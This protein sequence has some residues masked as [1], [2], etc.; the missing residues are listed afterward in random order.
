MYSK[1]K[2]LREFLGNK[3]GAI[4][5]TFI[6]IL[7][8]FYGDDIS[9]LTFIAVV[10]RLRSSYLLHTPQESERY[11]RFPFALLYTNDGSESRYVASTLQNVQTLCP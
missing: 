2:I 4:S 7:R 6:D 10:D 1:D 9:R 11:E 5:K 8:S 3:E